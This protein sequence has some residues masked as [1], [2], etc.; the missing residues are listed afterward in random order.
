MSV[1][2]KVIFIDMDG[3]LLPFPNSTPLPPGKLFPTSTLK[4][5]ARLWKHVENSNKKNQTNN[6]AVEWVLSSTWRVQERYIRDIE[7]ALQEFGIPLTFS[8]ITD[9]N[10]HTERQWEIQ[11]WWN[12]QQHQLNH[13]N[14]SRH[15]SQSCVWL[16]LD[17]EE[18]LEGEKNEKYQSLFQGH[19]VKP[20]SHVGL[21]EQDVDLAIRLWDS[22]LAALTS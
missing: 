20:A 6:N 16:A 15:L 13:D 21:S 10:N 18:L 17:D 7:E 4:P 12:Q 3:V 5:L 22:Q 9:P 2:R 1:P 19:V 14:R 8:D 11:E